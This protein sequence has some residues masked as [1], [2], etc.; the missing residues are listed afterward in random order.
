MP[1]GG[2]ADVTLTMSHYMR[3]AVNTVANEILQEQYTQKRW[4]PWDQEPLPGFTMQPQAC[5]IWKGL[6]VVGCTRKAVGKFIVNG[7]SYFVVAFDDETVHL[8]VFPEYAKK[9]EEEPAVDAGEADDEGSG[10]EAGSRRRG[11]RRRR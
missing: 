1:D 5:W 3:I 9:D 10:D 2:L 6:E 11:R 8:K 4:M 7:Y